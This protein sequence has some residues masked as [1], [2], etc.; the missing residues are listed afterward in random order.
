MKNCSLFN[1]VSVDPM[2]AGDVV[3]ERP[4]YG[5]YGM[6]DPHGNADCQFRQG[7]HGGRIDAITSHLHFRY[8][9]L[10][11]TPMRWMQQDP[12]GYVDDLDAFQAD[13]NNPTNELDPDGT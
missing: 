8:R 3:E 13:R 2:A 10:N 7:H 12:L 5:A 4:G 1:P 11:T 6:H 9:E